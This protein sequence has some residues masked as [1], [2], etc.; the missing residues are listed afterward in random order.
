MRDGSRGHTFKVMDGLQAN[1][2]M[3]GPSKDQAGRSTRVSGAPLR[4]ALTCARVFPLSSEI[5]FMTERRGWMSRMR[6]SVKIILRGPKGR[7]PPSTYFPVRRP[8]GGGSVDERNN[9]ASG[10]MSVVCGFK[11]NCLE[12]VLQQRNQIYTRAP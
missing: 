2:W 4:P 10:I 9:S 8:E 11:L 3:A 7:L 12:S 6:L 5:A 1:V